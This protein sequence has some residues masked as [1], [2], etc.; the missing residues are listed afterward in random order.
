MTWHYLKNAPYPSQSLLK[1]SRKL[2]MKPTL[3][4][5]KQGLQACLTAQQAHRTALCWPHQRAQGI[6]LLEAPSSLMTNPKGTR[7]DPSLPPA[8]PNHFC[9]LLANRRSS[10]TGN[11]AQKTTEIY[12]FGWH[13]LK[14]LKS[15]DNIIWRI[16]PSTTGSTPQYIHAS[17]RNT[18]LVS[19]NLNEY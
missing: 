10:R 13:N 17:W 4:G 1:P 5:I 3:V 16:S 18:R 9:W 19:L 15:G 6:M 8:I 11:I 12:Q 2:K 14:E 7:R